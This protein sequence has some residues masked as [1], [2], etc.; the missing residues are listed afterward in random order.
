MSKKNYNSLFRPGPNSCLNACIGTN[1]GPYDYS[2]YAEGFFQA[3]HTIIDST[4]IGSVTIDLVIYPAA[5]SY[6][7]GIELYIKHFIRIIETY[8]RNG[9]IKSKGHRLLDLWEKFISLV[10]AIPGDPLLDPSE[11]A[12][13][14]DIIEDFEHIDENGEVFR[15]PEDNQRNPHLSGMSH[16]NVEILQ[17]GM[18]ELLNL[19]E[20]LEASLLVLQNEGH[21][22]N[23]PI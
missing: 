9:N 19:F 17:Q 21:G 12:C 16:I 20:N 22:A 3:G 10:D 18:R 7:Q 1:G 11:V 6:R 4:K 8:N 13:A 2:A 15:Y 14:R 23:D 5:F